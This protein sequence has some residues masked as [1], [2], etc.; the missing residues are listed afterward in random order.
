MSPSTALLA[1][2]CRLSYSMK[3]DLVLP[4]LVMPDLTA[5]TAARSAITAGG[6][7]IFKPGDATAT[8]AYP[9]AVG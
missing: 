1:L 8:T 9:C 6:Q 2:Y 4:T 5:E 7:P 3:F